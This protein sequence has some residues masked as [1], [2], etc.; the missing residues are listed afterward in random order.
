MPKTAIQKGAGDHRRDLA[1]DIL[2]QRK[3]NVALLNRMVQKQDD[4]LDSSEDMEGVELFFTSQRT[5]FD[6][7]VK[8]MNPGSAG[9]GTT[10]PTDPDTHGGLP[11]NL[12]HSGHAK[13]YNRIGELPELIGKVKAAYQ[14]LLELKKEEV[15]ETIRQCM[16]DVHQLAGEARDAGAL[17]K[18]ADDYFAAKRDAA[19]EAG[20]LTELD[21]MITPTT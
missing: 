2:S 20:S 19:K 12:R 13:P 1:Q 21:A 18:Q 10:S 8:Q 11:H 14:S 3:D 9:S 6:E 4:L 15:A 17:L 7:A 16:Q 5:V